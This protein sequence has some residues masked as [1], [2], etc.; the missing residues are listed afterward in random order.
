MEKIYY[1]NET[2]PERTWDEC[3]DA[4]K[5]WN[6]TDS[7][8]P[9]KKKVM[10]DYKLKRA[11]NMMWQIDKLS[12]EYTG[13]VGE[14]D[15]FQMLKDEYMDKVATGTDPHDERPQ[16]NDESSHSAEPD[17]L[18][19]ESKKSRRTRKQLKQHMK[20]YKILCNETELLL[21]PLTEE[22]I[23]NAHG[24]L[25]DGLTSGGTPI[26]AG[27]YRT[28]DVN[29]A[30]SDQVFPSAEAIP[31]AMKKIVKE[32]NE[33][34]SQ[35]HDMY[36]LAS[37]L[38]FQI[39]TLHPFEDGNGRMCRLLWCYSL[40]KDGLPFPLT[41]SSGHKKAYKHYVKCIENDARRS[42]RN[43]PAD[44]Y[45]HLTTLTV[46]SVNHAWSNFYNNLEFELT[47]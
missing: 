38:L 20:A 39:V 8:D 25:M 22:L 3:V 15:T 29:I 41:I 5:K 31:K 35:E 6:E 13:S 33:K 9:D 2:E 34:R 21:R 47:D 10:T 28:E 14:S 26:R 32:Y 37:W 19:A 11:L 43:R 30:G 40:M 45:G 36:Q 18:D 24:L 12:G 4:L 27:E 42:L 7:K 1:L 46:H 44:E 23:K 16:Q 17:E